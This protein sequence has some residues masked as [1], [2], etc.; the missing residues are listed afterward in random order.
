MFPSQAFSAY[1]EY[2]FWC[3]IYSP[4]SPTGQQKVVM[5]A[6]TSPYFGLLV[7]LNLNIELRTLY[8]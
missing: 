6:S 8:F 7:G 2:L 5:D 3:A 1:Q 4:D